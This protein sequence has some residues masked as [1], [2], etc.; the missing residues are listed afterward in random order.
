MLSSDTED[1]DVA[2]GF[3]VGPVGFI[4]RSVAEVQALL[5]S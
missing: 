3:G 4:Q 5:E 2:G 1:K